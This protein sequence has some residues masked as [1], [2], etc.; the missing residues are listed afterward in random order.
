MQIGQFDLL[1]L[2]L[3]FALK[4]FI[5]KGSKKIQNV[6]NVNLKVAH[7]LGVSG[8]IA[9]KNRLRTAMEDVMQAVHLNERSSTARTFIT[10]MPNC[11]C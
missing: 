2:L 5:F 4:V 7:Y 1:N 6:K 11:T 10:R 3:F 8:A 9:I